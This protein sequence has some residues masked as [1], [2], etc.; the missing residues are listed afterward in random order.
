MDHKPHTGYSAMATVSRTAF[1]IG[2]KM[3]ETR[4][5]DAVKLT[6]ELDAA[7]QSLQPAAG[8]IE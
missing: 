8:T 1:G 3:P 4:L 7:R 5:S 6:I 2:T